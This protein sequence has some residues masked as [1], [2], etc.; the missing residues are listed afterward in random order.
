M[1]TINDGEKTS[2]RKEERRRELEL[3]LPFLSL[4]YRHKNFD[5]FAREE[6]FMENAQVG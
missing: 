1:K 6:N 4:D 5:S 2:E 3:N